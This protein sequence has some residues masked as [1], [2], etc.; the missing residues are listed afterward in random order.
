MH[1]SQTWLYFGKGFAH[2]VK[3]ACR[4]SK[5]NFSSCLTNAIVVI[6][7]QLGK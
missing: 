1:P 7:W 4:K 3:L 2:R 6:G 5:E